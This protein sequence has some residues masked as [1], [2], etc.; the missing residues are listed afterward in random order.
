M[1]DMF[2]GSDHIA[3]SINNINEGLDCLVV[4]VSNAFHT[5]AVGF[6]VG[7]IRCGTIGSFSS[8]GQPV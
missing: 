8:W 6:F 5:I 1:F 2:H 4:V 7:S 3:V